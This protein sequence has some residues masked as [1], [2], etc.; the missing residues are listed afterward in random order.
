MNI[1]L[2]TAVAVESRQLRTAL[3]LQE[4]APGQFAGEAQGHHF[5]LLH[6]G[7]GIVNAAYRLGQILA[8]QPFDLGIQ[9]GIAGSFDLEL[10]LGTVVEITRDAF[11]EMGAEQPGGFMDM[12]AMGFA[13]LEKGE[14]RWYNWLE[15][16]TP[17]PCVL[18]KVAGITVNTVHGEATSIEAAAT[19][20]QATAET[21]EG[22]AFFYAMLREGIP[23]YA[24]RGISNHVT[25][26]TRGNWEV[27][28]A[29]D[30]AQAFVLEALHKERIG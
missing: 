5:T 8:R 24:F 19:R 12:E 17:S 22:A 15:N 3:S 10:P 28:L 29:A 7:V 11:S 13:V 23:F 21:M 16:P 25:P 1:L 6:T 4:T 18:P 26:R 30:Q 14:K 20:W 2:V 27:A 9:L